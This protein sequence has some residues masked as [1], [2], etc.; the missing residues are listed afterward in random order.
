MLKIFK[1]RNLAS[2]GLRREFDF[3]C[4]TKFAATLIDFELS[5]SLGDPSS[6]TIR[7]RLADI[8]K[9][10]RFSLSI[11]SKRETQVPIIAK[12]IGYVS[13]TARPT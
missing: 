10:Y 4:S 1:M 6:C 12:E 9:L 13:Y 7:R 8:S 2:S 3:V 11:E 5:S